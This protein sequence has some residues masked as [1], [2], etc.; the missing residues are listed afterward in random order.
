MSTV[1][2]FTHNFEQTC[3]RV[4]QSVNVCVCLCVCV[5]VCLCVRAC[6]CV[7][8]MGGGG[9]GL[10]TGMFPSFFL[11]FFWFS[12]FTKNSASL[13]VRFTRMRLS[14]SMCVCAHASVS[15]RKCLCVRVFRRRVS[16]YLSIWGG[17]GGGGGKDDSERDHGSGGGWLRGWD[18]GTTQRPR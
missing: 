17:G 4:W 16:V 7:C 13:C 15:G 2:Y 5:C 6:V 3:L 8:R 18:G 1:F 10:K 11:S 14:G 12:D 9:G